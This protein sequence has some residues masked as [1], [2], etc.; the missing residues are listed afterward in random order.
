M[1]LDITWMIV[2]LKVLSWLFLNVWLQEQEMESLL[3][4]GVQE[5]LKNASQLRKNFLSKLTVH[6]QKNMLTQQYQIV[7]V[8]QK[9]K[10]IRM[11]VLVLELKDA[12]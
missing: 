11:N 10:Q 8:F 7:N 9:T 2:S 1:M 12:Y 3:V 5:I 4:I 6:K